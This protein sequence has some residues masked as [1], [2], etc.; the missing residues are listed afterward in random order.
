MGRRLTER[1][2]DHVVLGRGGVANAWRTERWD[3]LRLLTPDW[4]RRL[5]GLG[6]QGDDPDG[7]AKVPEVVAFVDRYARTISAP[8]RTGTR[9]TSARR[10]STCPSARVGDR[11]PPRLPLA[12]SA[13]ARP[14]LSPVAPAAA[15][16]RGRR[17]AASRRPRWS[18]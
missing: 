3:S 8:V 13:G 5:P 16:P 18:A 10:A 9:V 7:F 6:Y 4:Q 11:L 17:S 2:I 12:G 14:Q 1:S 15:H